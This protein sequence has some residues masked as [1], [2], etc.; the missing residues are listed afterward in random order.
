MELDFFGFYNVTGRRVRERLA[1]ER[2]EYMKRTAPAKY[3][4]A[5]TPKTE[6]GCKRKVNDTDYFACLHN[7]NM[8]L[9]HADPIEEITATGVRTRSG[10]EIRAD[11][12]ILANGFETQRVLYPLDIRG[13]KGIS[14]TEHVSNYP[15]SVSAASRILNIDK[16]AVG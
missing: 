1:R 13:E 15:L 6:L 7:E 2:I 5:L 16:R 10:R 3:H 12:I 11:A 9:V 8:E 4:E 14:L